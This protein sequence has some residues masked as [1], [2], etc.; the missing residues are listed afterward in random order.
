ME[1][2]CASCRQ[3]HGFATAPNS[4]ILRTLLAMASGPCAAAAAALEAAVSLAEEARPAS[5]APHPNPGPAASWAGPAEG[6]SDAAALSLRVSALCYGCS[7]RLRLAW[8]RY[9]ERHS[10][11]RAGAGGPA[12]GAPAASRPGRGKAGRAR[13][14]RARRGRRG[15]GGGRRGAGARAGG[16]ERGRR[17]RRLCARAAR[18]GGGGGRGGRAQWRPQVAGP[19]PPLRSA[20]RSWRWCA[21]AAASSIVPRQTGCLWPHAAMHRL[22]SPFMR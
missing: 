21:H 10:P 18:R 11:G 5:A 8:R 4:R 13:Q 7:C 17:R 1:W 15:R 16:R 22:C 9:D 3:R 19:A 2:R 20:N 6:F 12:R 14:W